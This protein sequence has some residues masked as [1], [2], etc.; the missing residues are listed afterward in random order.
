MPP[1]SLL[2]RLFWDL[3]NVQSVVEHN[4]DRIS[5]QPPVGVRVF[6]QLPGEFCRSDYDRPRDALAGVQS[7][8]TDA[9][10]LEIVSRHVERFFRMLLLVL[11]DREHSLSPTDVAV[12]DDLVHRAFGN[13]EI[14]VRDLVRRVA[15]DVYGL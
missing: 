12:S 10:S 5:Q 8:S 7:D 3:K 11:T 13:K 4:F 15:C 6:F 1:C 2:G 9:V 14:E